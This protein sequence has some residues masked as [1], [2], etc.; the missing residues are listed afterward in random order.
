MPVD[1]INVARV[2]DPV[3]VPG[4]RGKVLVPRTPN[5]RPGRT[6]RGTLRFA[7][8]HPP[9][10]GTRPLGAGVTAPADLLDLLVGSLEP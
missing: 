2:G 3:R 5:P 8:G 6:P 10:A 9:L 4:A 1:T 7:A